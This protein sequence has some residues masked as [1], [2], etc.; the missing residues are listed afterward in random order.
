M[1]GPEHIH[2]QCRQFVLAWIYENGGEVA[3]SS[4]QSIGDVLAVGDGAS[5]DHSIYVSVGG[6]C[7]RSQPPCDAVDHGVE[8]QLGLLVALG[9]ASLHLSHVVGAQMGE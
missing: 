3:Q 8:H 1:H 7:Q 9:D 6:W 4:F 5:E 2:G